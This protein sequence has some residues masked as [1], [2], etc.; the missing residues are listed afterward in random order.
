M[1]SEIT[2]D[3]PA[4]NAKQ[5]MFLDAATKYVAYGGA[6]GGGKSWVVRVQALRYA[7]KY[8][9]IEQVIVRHTYDELYKNHIKPLLAMVP[10]EA[11]QYNDS[12]KE[13]RFPNGS[14]LSFTYCSNDKDLDHFQGVEYDVLY[15]DEATQYTEE[16][17]RTMAACVRS[18]TA[19]KPRRIYL[20]CNPGG[21]GHTWMKRL[22]ID[23]AFSTNERAE[24]YSF[25]QAKA[26]DNK[27]LMRANPDYIP[28]LEALPPKKRAAWLDGDWDIFEGQ[29]FEDFQ[30]RPDM[31]AAREHG[32]NESAETLTEQ[33]RWTHVI[34]PFEIPR[35]WNICRSYDFG[36][37]KPFSCA[38]WAVDFDGTLYRIM[39]LYGCT[40]TA[41]E[42]VRWT[43]DQQFRKI[44][45][46]ETTHPW[47]KGKNITGVA[48]P[49]IWDSSR[50]ESI[51]ETAARYGVYFTPGDNNRIPGWMQCHY[52]LQFDENGYSRMYVFSNCKAFVR[53][54]PLMLY[55]STQTE[56]L[57][58]K[59]E[60]HVCD[61]WRY[62]CMSRPVKPIVPVKQKD[63][64]SDPL[65]QFK[66]KRR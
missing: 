21:I 8:P 15:I 27:A 54:V 4:P 35:G 44:R 39:E 49:A 22:F 65:D 60:D 9:G 43:P 56:D 46:T 40:E 29:F 26:Q 24:E 16:Q 20:T 48:D 52:R 18:A 47:L 50:G 62:M 30:S 32:V 12:K 10:R 17:F 45:E 42:G 11:R 28:Q 6:R 2:I 38:W 5:R 23:R 53:T 1:S 3:I 34:E 14:V 33:R 66:N 36:Y 51:A 19:G 63:I 58:T 64:L 55:S 59:L 7:F 31:K 13:L 25:I 37:G 57:D 41:N 61:E